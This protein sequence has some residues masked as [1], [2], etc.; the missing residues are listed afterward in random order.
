MISR[1]RSGLARA[2]LAALFWNAAHA[3][4]LIRRLRPAIL[5]LAWRCSPGLRRGPRANA[6]R[7]LGPASTPGER[8]RLARAVASHF[9][10]A[11]VEMG[12]NRARAP[13]DLLA[14]L[15][16]V[17]GEEAYRALRA[18]RRGAILVTAHLGHFET[19][20]AMLA[21]VEPRIHVVFSRDES[22][23]FER[24]RARQHARLGVLD[25]PVNDGLE[26]W[27][28]LRDALDADEVVLMQGDRV[29]PGQPGA[30][31]PFLGGHLRLPLGPVKLARLTGAPLIPVFAVADDDGRIR[32]AIEPPIDLGDGPV[33]GQDDPALAR[34]A[35]VIEEYVRRYP[36]QWMCL[37]PALCEDE[38]VPTGGAPK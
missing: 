3:P 18:R 17:D 14:R 30:R 5:T 16:R 13:S 23:L 38:T 12:A 6:A 37:H 9:L 35:S 31:V 2:W 26:M 20:I 36:D 15:G 11:V 28:R 34:L 27:V 8:E 19:A 4:G 29:M 10:D 25:A 1:V 24:L 32:I 33:R 7:L 21:R 22:M